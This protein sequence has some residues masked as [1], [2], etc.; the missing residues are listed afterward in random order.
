LVNCE[1]GEIGEW[2]MGRSK[3]ESDP[4]LFDEFVEFQ[5]IVW[6]II[7]S[8]FLKVNDKF[9]FRDNLLGEATEHPTF[10]C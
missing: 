10:V 8:E 6:S 4:L 9:V 3:I 5:K 1:I 2:G 7:F